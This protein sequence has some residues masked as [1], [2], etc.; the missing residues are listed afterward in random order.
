M[1]MICGVQDVFGQ[2]F[3]DKVKD[4]SFYVQTFLINVWN[5]KNGINDTFM[6][7]KPNFIDCPSMLERANFNDE[8]RS[9]S[10]KHFI[11]LGQVAMF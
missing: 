8:D 3:N 1:S 7:H 9:C 10:N 2:R 4:A 5:S 11:A 6:I